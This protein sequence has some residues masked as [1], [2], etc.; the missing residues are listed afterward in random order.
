MLAR[1]HQDKEGLEYILRRSSA[2]FPTLPPTQIPKLLLPREF[3][4]LRADFIPEVIIIRPALLMGTGDPKEQPRGAGKTR[5]GEGIKTWTVNRAEV[6][7]FI[8]D[9]CLPGSGGEKWVNKAPTVG[10]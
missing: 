8:V 9:E 5:I 6:G 3:E 10:W 4:G 1:P 7:R 2:I